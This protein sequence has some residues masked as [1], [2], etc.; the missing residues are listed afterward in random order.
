MKE[1]TIREIRDNS[2]QHLYFKEPRG[3]RNLAQSHNRMEHPSSFIFFIHF[4]PQKPPGKQTIN[5][6]S[7]RNS[8]ATLN[9]WS[10]WQ[11]T[12]PFTCINPSVKQKRKMLF[13]PHFMLEKTEAQEDPG[14]GP[15]K[16]QVSLRIHGGIPC[17]TH[18]TWEPLSLPAL[19][20]HECLQHLQKSVSVL[21]FFFTMHMKWETG[22][23]KH[24]HWAR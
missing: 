21:A 16:D 14:P 19:F 5:S 20:H 1:E 15:A 2:L 23:G 6:K 18:W 10:T 9:F 13:F 3:W 7:S 17:V 12:D 4:I 11:S 22:K 8:N 24:I